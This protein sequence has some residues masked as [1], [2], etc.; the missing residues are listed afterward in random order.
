[1]HTETRAFSA[2]SIDC[3]ACHGPVDRA[4]T[5]DTAV[6]LLSKKNQKPR[7]VISICGQCHLRGGKSKSS[8]LPYPN[9]F[10]AGDNLFR[11]FDVDLSSDAIGELS[12]ADR[13]I[14]DNTRDVVVLGREELTCLSCH[15]VHTQRT[16]KHQELNASR[17]CS[18]CHVPESDNTELR[19]SFLE[20]RGPV[21][22]SQVC[23]Y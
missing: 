3:F 23:D 13:H 11:D 10:V 21:A 5:K 7:E 17:I 16:E 18:T 20:S 1:V 19:E 8:E 15:D 9:T 6:V 12:P 22:H 4:H 2:T 14:F